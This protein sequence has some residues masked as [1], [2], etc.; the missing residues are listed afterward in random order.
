MPFIGKTGRNSRPKRAPALT[1][2]RLVALWPSETLTAAS[3]E[4]AVLEA[5]AV[6]ADEGEADAM[7]FLDV[8][9]DWPPDED[10]FWREPPDDAG[11]A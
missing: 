8:V 9:R 11:G 4:Q 6:A 3:R 10:V 7:A 5:H 1:G 2:A